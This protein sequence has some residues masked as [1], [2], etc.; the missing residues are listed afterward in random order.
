M[1]SKRALQLRVDPPGGGAEV[2]T[3]TFRESGIGVPVPE[4]TIP[5]SMST[6]IQSCPLS[7]C[8]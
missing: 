2:R 6:C 7:T 3:P 1:D 5:V 4:F 8:Q